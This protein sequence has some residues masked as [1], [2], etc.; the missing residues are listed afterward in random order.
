MKRRLRL[1][2]LLL[3]VLG[4]AAWGVVRWIESRALVPGPGDQATVIVGR[5]SGAQQI[6]AQL[7]DAGAVPSST[8]FLAELTLAHSPSLK[9]GEYAIP[10]HA[11]MASIIDMMHRGLVVRHKL[12]IPE[13]LTAKQVMALVDA[14]D[15]MRGHL[16]RPPPEGS[17]LP[18]TY[19]YLYDDP[20]DMIVV[21]MTEAMTQALDTLWAARAPDLPIADKAQAVI[22]ASIVER[23][24]A[25]PAERPH[26]ASVYENRLR[27]HMKLEADPTVVY[28]VSDGL[29]VLD[30]PLS[31]ADLTTANPFNTYMNEGLPPGPICN[32]GRA[33]IEAV[34]HPAAT[35]DLYFVADGSGGHA[36]AKTLAQH[37]KNVEK[38]RELQKVQGNGREE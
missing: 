35:D 2:I 14:A 20:R 9:A 4:I 5:G 23:E 12:T 30:R 11:T 8:L 19:F 7:A 10:P 33:S 17:V 1:P 16:L 22:L 26:V 6:A 28:G 21:R 29:G 15:L 32:P 38:W 34:L 36:F 18:Q 24:T 27:Q 3:L 25:L 31:R 37:N 13:G